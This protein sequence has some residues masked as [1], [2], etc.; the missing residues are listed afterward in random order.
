M[1]RII[2]SILLIVVLATG[3]IASLTSCIGPNKTPTTEF[4]I[5]DGGYDGSAVTIKFYHTMGAALTTILTD[6]IAEFNELYPNIT[7]EHASYGDYDAL[8]AQ[9]STEITVGNQPHLAYCYPDHV[10]TYNVAGAVQNLDELVA[11]TIEQKNEKGSETLGYTQDQLNDFISAY[12]AEG[13]SYGDGKMYSVALAKSTEVLYYNVDALK[14]AGVVDA[15]GNVAPPTTWEEVEAACEKLKAWDPNCIPLGYDSESNWFITMC[16]QYGSPYTSATGDNFLFDND[17]NKSFIKTFR[18]WYKNKLVTTKELSG[19][20]TS[21]LFTGNT[22]RATEGSEAAKGTRCYMCIGSTGGATYQRPATDSKKDNG[23]EFEVGIAPIP[24]VEGNAPKV[25]SQGPSL[26]VFKK[27][28]VQEV[29]A[30]WLFAK[31]LTTNVQY[32][33]RVSESNGYVPVMK[34]VQ[35]DPLYQEFLS[36]IDPATGKENLT[37]YITAYA[38]RVAID[39]AE[40]CY[41]SPAFNGSSVARIQVGYLVQKCLVIATD[42][43][44]DAAINKAFSDCV[45]EC[46]YQIGK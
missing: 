11:S 13:K 27:A 37:K 31:F 23:Y 12:Y 17:T 36:A 2:A 42:E 5:P 25:I 20:Y 29:L 43:G 28:N 10:A 39:Q 1:K 41:T 22:S 9:I 32:Q 4:V 8:L 44:L 21:D 14:A 18:E 3:M 15:D 33:A 16:E 40:N 45:A 38:V 46:N 35:N 7:I 19:G 6:A 34:S 24:H 26:C 30:S